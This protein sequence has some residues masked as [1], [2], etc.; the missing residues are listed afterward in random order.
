[1]IPGHIEWFTRPDPEGGGVWIEAKVMNWK[2]KVWHQVFWSS[3]IDLPHYT[4][5]DIVC[6]IQERFQRVCPHKRLIKPP[7]R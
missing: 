7:I 2:K 1:M 4:F 6:M 5:L 3:S